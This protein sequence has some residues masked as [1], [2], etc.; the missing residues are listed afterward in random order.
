MCAET[1]SIYRVAVLQN[2]LPLV[3]RNTT[4]AEGSR[5][6]TVNSRTPFST[7]LPFRGQTYLELE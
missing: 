3:A 2:L 7:A 4:L 6:G 1:V 5:T